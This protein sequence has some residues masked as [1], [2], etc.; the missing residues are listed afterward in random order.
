M[1]RATI[2]VG[3]VFSAVAT[4]A[5]PPNTS[6]APITAALFQCRSSG[7]SR[8]FSSRNAKSRVPA[9]RNRIA[10]PTNA[11]MDAFTFAMPKYVV[12]QTM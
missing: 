5:L 1:M 6:R 8:V 2:P 3:T 4:I 9:T 11:G 7:R 12:L 10:A